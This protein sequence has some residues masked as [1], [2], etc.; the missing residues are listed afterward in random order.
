[1]RA[2]LQAVVSATDDSMRND[3]TAYTEAVGH[4]IDT[5]QKNRSRLCSVGVRMQGRWSRVTSCLALPS[6]VR[7]CTLTTG[8]PRTGDERGAL[9]AHRSGLVCECPV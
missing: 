3:N 5:S 1:M 7:G 2:S 9:E 6:T 4:V 8:G